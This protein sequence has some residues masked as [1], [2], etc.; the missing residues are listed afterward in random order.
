MNR[1]ILKYKN[2]E[3][4][5]EHPEFSLIQNTVHVCASISTTEGMV[6][7]YGNKFKA[8]IISVGYLVEQILGEWSD[9][10]IKF[11]QYI[12]L[13][14]RIKDLTKASSK[15]KKMLRGVRRNQKE[16]LEAI[17]LLT[18][19][20][21]YPEDFNPET[22]EEKIFVKLWDLIDTEE[23]ILRFRNEYHNN[24]NDAEYFK[25]KFTAALMKAVNN[26][27][28]SDYVEAVEG[29]DNFY[30]TWSK[31]VYDNMPKQIVFHGFYYITHIQDKLIRLIENLGIEIIFLNCY[32]ENYPKMFKIWEDNFNTKD[33]YEPLDRWIGNPM[34]KEKESWGNIFARIYEG[35]D[36]KGIEPK[37]SLKLVQYKDTTSFIYNY[38]EEEK[39][40][41]P[42]ARNLNT[43]FK[44][45][46]PERYKDRHFL[47]YP[48]G[49]FLFELHRMW[50]EDLGEL[51]LSMEA[52]EQ[53]F[54]S[55]WLHKNGIQ[56]KDY[57]QDLK[58]IE[59]YFKGCTTLEYWIQRFK[60]LRETKVSVVEQFNSSIDKT[61]ENYRFHNMLSNPFLHFSFFNIPV[62]RLDMVIEF[63]ERIVEI[64]EELFAGNKEIKL[65]DYLDKLRKLIEEQCPE[66]MIYEKEKEIIEELKVRLSTDVEYF[67]SCFPEDISEAIM[68]FLGG[69]FGKSKEREEDDLDQIVLHLSRIEGEVLKNKGEV[70]HAC[71]ISEDVL[72]GDKGRMPWPLNEKNIGKIDTAKRKDSRR[73]IER[74][75]FL[76]REQ[77]LINR[78]L[79]YSSLQV[80]TDIKLSWIRDW[81]DKEI[82]ESVFI[83]L[84]K[85][86]EPSI[87]LRVEG[88]DF[89]TR[90]FEQVKAIEEKEP[91]NVNEITSMPEEVIEEFLICP[92]KFF[93]SY[94]A[95]EQPT[96]VSDF[97]HGFV[98]TALVR[99]VSSA[100]KCSAKTAFEEMK[101]FFP[102]W[103][104][105]EKR[106]L[107]EYASH[108]SKAEYSSYDGISYLRHRKDIHFLNG[109]F[110]D[111]I[112]EEQISNEVVGEKTNRLLF[113][114]SPSREKCMYCPHIDYCLDAVHPLDKEEEQ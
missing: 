96:Y 63:V 103:R 77:K 30:R 111:S 106:Q 5:N 110:K 68:I 92:R 23:S 16:V 20:G 22:A 25:K 27:A 46:Y 60:D 49:Q 74:V 97:H 54:A 36:I 83:K 95:K 112:N 47:S 58:L 17:R 59:S 48:I 108:V 12:E 71:R 79:F 72:P 18:E 15:Y 73:L 10:L 82:S 45:Y 43:I 34:E 90:S 51:V 88:E 107:S 64:A 69:E 50:D 28:A 84:L 81:E 100:A 52:I 65:K 104:D 101:N 31:E 6:L 1:K 114:S 98:F 35:R 9:E 78:Y 38:K 39:Y 11:G 61:N 99:A 109:N 2:M 75:V 44:Q 80:N 113:F 62:E 102:Q 67:N 40:Y 76:Y 85:M 93:Y 7:Y 33:G 89:N 3:D 57:T 56:A 66:N 8:P 29:L 42:D 87:P 21:V 105:L 14:R 26:E 53:C 86:W 19:I 13:T 41:S 32:D 94:V 91:L 55:G 70:L 4:L 37:N 24:F